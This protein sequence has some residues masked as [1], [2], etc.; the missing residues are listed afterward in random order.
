MKQCSATP[1][2]TTTLSHLCVTPDTHPPIQRQEALADMPKNAKSI[3]LLGRVLAHLP[4]CRDKAK[5]AF[6]KALALDP[7]TIDACCALAD[8]HLSQGEVEACAVLLRGSL[9]HAGHHDFLWAKLGECHTLAGDYSAAMEAFHAAIS[10]N[11]SSGAAAEGL[12]R[13]EKLMRGM[14]PDLGE[15]E[16]DDDDGAMEA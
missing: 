3:T 4:E 15:R 2:I 16:E 11:P 14:D 7:M 1:S 5:R 6:Q 8:L 13:L 12:E 10:A 9:E